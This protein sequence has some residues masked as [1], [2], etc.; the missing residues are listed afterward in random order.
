MLVG[1]SG[2]SH[3]IGFRSRN[4]MPFFEESKDD[5]RFNQAVVQESE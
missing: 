2:G 4:K 3:C 5:G 1:L